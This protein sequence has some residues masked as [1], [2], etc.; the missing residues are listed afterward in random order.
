[1]KILNLANSTPEQLADATA[2]PPLG[3]ATD[4]SLIYNPKPLFLPETSEQ[5]QLQLSAAVIV[6]RLG[7]RIARRFAARYYEEFTCVAHAIP[8]SD[9]IESTPWAEAVDSA[10][11]I[12]ERC[13][14]AELASTPFEVDSPC[15]LTIHGLLPDVAA[16]AIESLSRFFTLKNGDIIV[17]PSRARFEVAEDMRL[18]VNCGDRAIISTRIK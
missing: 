11:V 16:L 14:A 6:N 4:S 2:F 3:V 1:M 18:E 8:A 10:W 5:W 9:N 7:K 13:R 12:G 17:L 15:R